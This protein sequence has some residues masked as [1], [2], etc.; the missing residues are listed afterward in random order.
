MNRLIL[1]LVTSNILLADIFTFQT[2]NKAKEAYEKGEF[3]KSARLF[4][5]LKEN[6]PSVAY[7]KANAFYKTGSYDE[8]LNAYEK[9]QGVDEA[10]RLYN[11]GN[12][13][14][15]K[16]EWDRAIEHYEKALNLKEDADTRY[17]LEL[18]K[19]K[20]KEKQ[21]KKNQDK[22]KQDQKKKE[23]QKK[24][25][26][27]KEN[28]K[29]KEEKK[30]SDEQKKAKTDDVNKKE[31]KEEKKMTPQEKKNEEM[32]KRELKHMMKQLAKKKMPTLMYQTNPKKGKRNEQN[33]W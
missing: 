20:K 2:I 24:R 6:D 18:A 32:R 7:D 11:M 30:N 12:S 9:A 13:Y 10:A 31:E 27:N 8:A 21:N 19:K 25:E 15:Q 23:N 33:P 14:F 4:G 5:R 17:N 28:Q 22:K 3:R 29:K 1:L 16:K 26:H